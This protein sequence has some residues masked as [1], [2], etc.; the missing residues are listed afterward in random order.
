MTA[1]LAQGQASCADEEHADVVI[2][3]L[4]TGGALDSTGSREA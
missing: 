1:S 2:L 3:F 4:A